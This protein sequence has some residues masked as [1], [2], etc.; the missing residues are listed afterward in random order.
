MVNA[1]SKVKPSSSRHWSC[2]T[3]CPAW[4]QRRARVGGGS[5]GA[6]R[7]G[8]RRCGPRGT[9]PTT[10]LFP[11]GRGGGTP[12]E[13]EGLSLPCS[14]STRGLTSTGGSPAGCAETGGEAVLVA[15]G[16]ASRS[17][18]ITH[19]SGCPLEQKEEREEARAEVLS[20]RSQAAD[21]GAG[22]LLTRALELVVEA[23]VSSPLLHSCG[24][25]SRGVSC[26]VW[27]CSRGRGRRGS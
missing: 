11:A 13:A 19:P 26:A 3:R 25:S 22:H 20:L 6:Q 2:L 16:S 12:E 5:T 27:G 7:K 9:T 15:D 14:S 21:A 8:T 23:Q 17:R 4:S 18:L 10:R 1:V 24:D